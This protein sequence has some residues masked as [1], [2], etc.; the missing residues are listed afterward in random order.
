MDIK[1]ITVVFALAAIFILATGVYY[2]KQAFTVQFENNLKRDKEITARLKDDKMHRAMEH[3]ERDIYQSIQIHNAY[4]D[5]INALSPT[6]NTIYQLSILIKPLYQIHSEVYEK[7]LEDKEIISL[8]D[9]SIEV[10]MLEKKTS[11]SSHELRSFVM[12]KVFETLLCFNPTKDNTIED[13]VETVVSKAHS[14]GGSKETLPKLT[15]KA[16]AT[17]GLDFKTFMEFYQYHTYSKKLLQNKG[18]DLEDSFNALSFT[19]TSQQHSKAGNVREFDYKNSFQKMKSFLSSDI[20]SGAFDCDVFEH[21]LIELPPNLFTHVSPL[22]RN[23][24]TISKSIS[25][26][27]AIQETHELLAF[28]QKCFDTLRAQLDE[29]D[30]LLLFYASFTP[31]AGKFEKNHSLNKEQLKNFPI[32]GMFPKEKVSLSVFHEF[33]LVRNINVFKHELIQGYRE[34]FDACTA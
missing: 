11:T 33:E 6:N 18:Y 17:F 13:Y 9:A 12:S 21:M 29:H 30:Q 4:K 10:D 24:Y 23:L 8:K 5:K 3:L 20:F 15:L 26:F 19:Y 14:S 25:N 16:P 34:E 7:C 31:Y 27:D 1:S 28:Q 22:L 32:E 2:V